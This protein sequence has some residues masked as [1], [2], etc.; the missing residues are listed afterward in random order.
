MSRNYLFFYLSVSPKYM[1]DNLAKW[2]EVGLKKRSIP[3]TGSICA[4]VRGCQRAWHLG[5]KQ[6]VPHVELEAGE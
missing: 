3:G 6:A 1:S 2:I 5:V 4:R